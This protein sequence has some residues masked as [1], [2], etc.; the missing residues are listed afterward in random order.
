MAKEAEEKSYTF[1]DMFV[2]LLDKQLVQLNDT[3]GMCCITEGIILDELPMTQEQENEFVQKMDNFPATN[4]T[5]YLFRNANFRIIPDFAKKELV[6]LFLQ[7][8]NTFQAS[9]P[10]TESLSRA[11]ESLGMLYNVSIESADFALKTSGEENRLIHDISGY[12]LDMLM[13]DA[14]REYQDTEFNRL[15]KNASPLDTAVI[16]VEYL[17]RHPELRHMLECAK[18]LRQKIRN[19]LKLGDNAFVG[20]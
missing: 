2:E 1:N 7:Y 17:S 14:K 20:F 6:E 3:F 11:K 19:E 10:T 5:L 16:I 8:K 13:L 12:D 9:A 18:A 4:E 15:Y